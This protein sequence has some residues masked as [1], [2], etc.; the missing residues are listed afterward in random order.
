MGLQVVGE[1]IESIGNLKC[2]SH[3]Y[4]LVA[5]HVGSSCKLL[6]L[7]DSVNAFLVVEHT[8]LFLEEF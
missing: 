3:R 7:A 5:Q 4:A 6:M 8:V 2:V 1:S